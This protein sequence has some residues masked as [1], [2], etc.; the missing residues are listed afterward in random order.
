MSKGIPVRIIYA[1]LSRD[2]AK[3]PIESISKIMEGVA[4]K[5]SITLDGKEVLEV[6]IISRYS[7]ESCKRIELGNSESY[8]ILYTKGDI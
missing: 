3:L 4:T 7:Y 6:H 8:N 1:D 2:I 5:K